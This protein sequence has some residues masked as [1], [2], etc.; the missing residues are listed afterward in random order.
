MLDKKIHANYDTKGHVLRLHSHLHDPNR[1]AE[2]NQRQKLIYQ[3]LR[4]PK[5][6]EDLAEL[7]DTTYHTVRRDLQVLLQTGIVKELPF[8]QKGTR[9]KLYQVAVLS[10][11]QGKTPGTIEP[12]LFS[13]MGQQL[14]I[15]D[16][17]PNLFVR[18]GAEAMEILSLAAVG[19]VWEWYVKND[20]T[21]SKPIAIFPPASVA[22]EKL[23]LVITF[24]ENCLEL[25]QQIYY[26][27]IWD[28]PE[29]DA[30]AVIGD[31]DKF[32]WKE[33]EERMV[34]L[35]QIATSNGWEPSP[36]LAKRLEKEAKN[37]V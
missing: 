8:P 19:A 31:P 13:Y 24:L 9:R 15:N 10:T 16:I 26:C 1:K 12:L 4:A 37:D 6:I 27:P 3:T 29:N 7:H 14:T 25:A 33:L 18:V 23:D 22:Q 20:P 21:N 36:E 32:N 5:T 34:R 11:A 28:D 17:N 30:I 35:H 2:M